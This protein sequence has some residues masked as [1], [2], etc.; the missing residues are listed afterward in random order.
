[1]TILPAGDGD[2]GDNNGAQFYD[3]AKPDPFRS[4]LYVHFTNHNFFNREWLDDDGAGPPVVARG[5]HERVLT[6]YG[7]AL[8]RSVLLGH[9]T[10]GFLAGDEKPAGVPVANMSPVLRVG[11][12]DDGR[13]PRG[14][15][16]D[17]HELA[18][19]RHLPVRRDERRRVSDGP[20]AGRSTTRSSASPSAWS[21]GAAGKVASSGPRSASATYGSSRSGCGPQRSGR[22]ASRPTRPGF[23]LGLE[24]AE[25]HDR[26]GR[27]RPGRRAPRPYDRDGYTKSMLNTLRFKASCFKT[28]EPRSTWAPSA[29]S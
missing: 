23:R 22:T 27:L 1:M 12:A 24:D 11:E 15:Q 8:F 16:H 10:D 13:R 3:Q 29:P 21:H 28:A 5:E 19:P 4:Q 14:R 7:S 20:A 17:R 26:L 18:R 2:V 9:G 6:V 25:R